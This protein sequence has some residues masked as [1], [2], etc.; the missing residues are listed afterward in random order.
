MEDLNNNNNKQ[1]L[2]YSFTNSIIFFKSTHRIF[3]NE[4][5]IRPQNVFIN[6]RRLKLYKVCTLSQ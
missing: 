1:D 2:R 5:Y 4:L 6:S 3:L